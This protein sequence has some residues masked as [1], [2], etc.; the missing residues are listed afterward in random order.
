MRTRPTTPNAH[1]TT[2]PACGGRL[3]LGRLVVRGGR[4]TPTFRCGCG[5]RWRDD[6]LR[7]P[8]AALRR[9]GLR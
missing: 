8:T 9:R 2:C 4:L 7:Y 3:T 1:R 6:E 5:E